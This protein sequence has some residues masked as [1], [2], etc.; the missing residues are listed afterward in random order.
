[1][2]VYSNQLRIEKFIESFIE[3]YTEIILDFD[4]P[5][6]EVHGNQETSSFSWILWQS[7]L[8]AIAYFPWRPIAY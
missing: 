8:F 5:D 2:I 4:A 3:L 1:M 7:L 6:D